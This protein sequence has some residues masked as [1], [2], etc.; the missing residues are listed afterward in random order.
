MTDHQISTPIEPIE[1]SHASRTEICA[2]LANDESRLGEIYNLLEAGK[3][4]DEIQAELGLE[5]NRFVWNYERVIKALRDGN[6]PTAPT[7]A[8]QTAQRFRTILK[9]NNLTGP[10]RTTLQH[11]LAVLEARS[12]DRSNQDRETEEAL[13]TTAQ[14]EAQGS[15]GIYVYTLPHYLH[16]PY[17][18]ET[19]RTLFKVG[20]SDRNII[21][22]FRNQTRT[23]ALPE[24]PVLLRIYRTGDIEKSGAIERHFHVT[25]EAAD[26]DRSTARTGGTEWF[27]TSLKF[28]DQIAGLLNLPVDAVLDNSD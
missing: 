7:V 27:L 23:T 26:H 14:L 3:T 16:H 5:Y 20:R 2:L 1:P 25:L 15:P 12:N 13:R 22:R 17:D 11:N 18:P 6:L 24:E 9:N 28:L 8:S 19:G 10:T 4:P 21:E